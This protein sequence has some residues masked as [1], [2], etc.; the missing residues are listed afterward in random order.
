MCVNIYM[1]THV[2]IYIHTYTVYL[3]KTL[4]KKGRSQKRGEHS[5][6]VVVVFT[7]EVPI[8]HDDN[9]ILLDGYM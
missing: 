4:K 7:T 6:L 5:N 9:Y 3:Y 1:F 8:I 2:C